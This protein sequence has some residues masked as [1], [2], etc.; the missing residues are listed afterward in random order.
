MTRA[1]VLVVGGDL[2]LR[3]ALCEK[4]A[5]AKGVE[6]AGEV[7]DGADLRGAVQ[8]AGA[9]VVVDAAFEAGTPEFDPT[10]PASVVV[11]VGD[12]DDAARIA[13]MVEAGAQAFV[14]R[15]ARDLAES[16]RR[17]ARGNVAVDPELGLRLLPALLQVNARRLESTAALELARESLT[18]QVQELLETTAA[19]ELARESL[20]AQFG[21]LLTTYRE[22]V[23]ALASA[24][25]LRDEYTGG[26]IERVAE[27]SLAIAGELDPALTDDPAV[28]GYMLHDIGKLALPD[29]VLFNAG[30]L[31][32]EQFEVVKRHTIEGARLVEGVPFLQ[33][34]LQIVRNHHERWEG[35]GYPDGLAGAEIP[36]IVRVFSISD[37]LDAITTERPYQAAR[38]LDFAVE[39]IG[40]KAGSQF[41]PDAVAAFRAVV[42][43]APAFSLLRQGIVPGSL[44]SRVDG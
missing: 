11:I 2:Q 25:E 37:A 33:P 29:A 44:I 5:A 40:A 7:G 26:H 30:P 24:V 34:A 39:E 9:N 32:A 23:K 38:P 43:T 28:L 42:E 16:V 15:G 21:E 27:Y 3:R 1:R 18:V 10:F 22:T 4:L 17:V 20:S 12:D 6:V 36:P 35:G 14:R 13:Q 8:R 19:L 41:D 31:S